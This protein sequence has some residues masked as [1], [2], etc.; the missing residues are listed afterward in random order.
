MRFFNRVVRRSRVTALLPILLLNLSISY[1]QPPPFHGW[2]GRWVNLGGDSISAP[3]TAS[4]G[5]FRLDVFVVGQN[6]NLWHLRWNGVTWSGWVDRGGGPIRQDPDC[7]ARRNTNIVEC[8]VLAGPPGD[9]IPWLLSWTGKFTGWVWHPLQQV[10][11]GGPESGVAITSWGP[12]RLDVFVVGGNR[13]LYHMSWNAFGGWSNWQI[14]GDVI[15]KGKP[16]CVSWPGRIDCFVRANSGRMW[17]LTGD[18]GTNW[19]WKL[20]GQKILGSP[21][22]VASKWPRH[23]DIFTTEHDG[24]NRN[25]MHM[26]YNPVSGFSNW[27]NLGRPTSDIPP[28]CPS[29]DITGSPSCESWGPDRIDCFVRTNFGY[30]WQKSWNKDFPYNLGPLIP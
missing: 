3:A 12:F 10:P 25:L 7:V 14:I 1:A 24:I 20:R 23:F 13:N 28:S 15:I 16:G 17:Q 18:G 8:V 21:P 9:V 2:G 19:T 22:T 29:C 11:A 27:R 30:T 6:Q 5:P 4:R 26:S